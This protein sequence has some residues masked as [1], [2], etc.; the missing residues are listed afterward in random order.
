MYIIILTPVLLE[1][2]VIPAWIF[3]SFLFCSHRINA[4]FFCISHSLLWSGQ[5]KEYQW[6][7]VVISVYWI[8]HIFLI[9]FLAYLIRRYLS[10]PWY[11]V[12]CLW[13]LRL[14]EISPF[15]YFFVTFDLH[16]WPLAFVKIT[17]TLVI[18]CIECCWMF[19]P[20][21][22]FGVPV[23]FEIWTFVYRAL[24]WRHYDVITNLILMKF[25]Y[26]SARSICK[27]YTKFQ[28]DQA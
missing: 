5:F 16:L 25:T 6:T 22:K 8:S 28:F 19:V 3:A 21:M 18:R 1:K 4:L 9:G 23:E 27:W 2:D 24:K 15:I 20:K 17:Y 10:L 26:K 11:Q 12:W 14:Y 13:V 7:I